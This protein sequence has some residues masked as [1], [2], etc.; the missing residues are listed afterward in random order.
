MLSFFLEN[1][2]V[3]LV[4]F[5]CLSHMALQIFNSHSE[6]SCWFEALW[7]YSSDEYCYVLH[8]D[9]LGYLDSVMAILKNSVNFHFH[10][11]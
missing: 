5:K 10:A 8:L 1:L 4:L 11:Y 6:F 3:I 2:R 7:C 9:A